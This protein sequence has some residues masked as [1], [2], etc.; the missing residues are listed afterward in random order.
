VEA[1]VESW[2]RVDEAFPSLV[3]C[4]KKRSCNLPVVF[5]YCLIK[6]LSSGYCKM[7]IPHLNGWLI[8]PINFVILLLHLYTLLILSCS[9]ISFTNSKDLIY[10]FF[11]ISLS[12]CLFLIILFIS[13]SLPSSL[14]AHHLFLFASPLQTHI[15]KSLYFICCLSFL[16]ATSV[17]LMLMIFLMFFHLFLC[18]CYFLAFY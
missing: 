10:Y 12:G 2:V 9:L 16:F 18:Y 8:F 5:F 6:I 14:T 7:Y 13:F 11:F 15:L 3:Q 1:K 4:E 17:L